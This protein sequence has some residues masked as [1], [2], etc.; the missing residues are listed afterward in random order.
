[1]SKYTNEQ[2][3]SLCEIIKEVGEE[4]TLSNELSE[5]LQE[6]KE[7]QSLDWETAV[8][9]CRNMQ[10]EAL[11]LGTVGYFYYMGCERL[12]DRYKKGERS[13]ELYEEMINLQ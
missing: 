10:G 13:R 1:M 2:L 12:L 7:C 5:A 8:E 11:M 9:N 3:K 4:I 6:Y